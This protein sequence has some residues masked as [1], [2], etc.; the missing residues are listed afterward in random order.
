M[1]Q[2]GRTVSRFL[3]SLP[4]AKAAVPKSLHLTDQILLARS[5]R[6]RKGRREGVQFSDAKSRSYPGCSGGAIERASPQA[7]MG[8][9][10][11]GP[12]KK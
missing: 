7:A 11:R 5:W 4:G 10:R 2:Y 8:L 6:L 1:A 9:G 12:G 3:G